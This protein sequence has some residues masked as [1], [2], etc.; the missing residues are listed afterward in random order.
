MMKKAI[1]SNDYSLC[2]KCGT[3]TFKGKCI[4][5]NHDVNAKRYRNKKLGEKR[6]KEINK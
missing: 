5:V 1:K 2:V 4:N 3:Y 6:L